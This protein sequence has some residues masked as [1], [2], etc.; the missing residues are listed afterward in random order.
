MTGGMA[1]TLVDI[2]VR[3]PS[4]SRS[5]ASNRVKLSRP[6][7]FLAAIRGVG[8]GVEDISFLHLR[9]SEASSRFGKFEGSH[10]HHHERYPGFMY[11]KVSHQSKAVADPRGRIG[12]PTIITPV[13]A[14]ASASYDGTV[15]TITF[16]RWS[17]SKADLEVVCVAIAT[18]LLATANKILYKMALVPM[19]EYPFFLAQLNTFGY[20]LLSVAR[21]FLFVKSS[22]M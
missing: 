9:S 10:H 13:A 2:G 16:A 1:Q 18:I 7:S 22:F 19:K 20:C 17:A 4:L 21:L 12:R 11:E 8:V 6:S 15:D 14:A 5:N 3:L